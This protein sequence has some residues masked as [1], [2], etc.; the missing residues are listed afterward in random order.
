MKTLLVDAILSLSPEEQ[1]LIR[2]KLQHHQGTEADSVEQI[3]LG[4]EEWIRQ[5][6][7]ILKTLF[8]SYALTRAE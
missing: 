1:Q 6:D 8:H 5:Q 2:E 3:H 4:R 7:G